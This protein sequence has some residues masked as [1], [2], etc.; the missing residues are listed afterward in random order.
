MASVDFDAWMDQC[1]GPGTV[2]YA[3]R[4]SA[5]DTLAN[6][7]HQAG[8]YIPREVLFTVLPILDRPERH[9]PDARFPLRID[10]HDGAPR[11]VR[12]IWYNNAL[13]G[14]TRNEARVTGFGGRRSPLL[15]PEN[16]GAV[17]VFAFMAGH[18][19]TVSQCRVWVCDCEAEESLF[20]QRLGPL[21]PGRWLVWSPDA[22][23]LLTPRPASATPCRL[24][25][26]DIPTAWLSAFP[27]GAEIVAET[28][29]MRPEHGYGPDDRL[30][31]RRD[32]EYEIFLSVE[33]AVEMPGIRAGF[34]TIDEFVSRA[35]SILQRRKARAGRSLELHAR[36]IFV[37][38]GLIEDEHFA[39]G[40]DSEPGRR[41]D[42]LFPSQERYRDHSFP[43]DRLRM[44]AVKTTCRDR[45]RQI[46]NEAGRIPIKHLL[47]VQEGVSEAQFREM[48]ESGVRLVV[49][50]RLR[51]HYPAVLRPELTSLEEFIADIRPLAGPTP[52][53]EGHA[54]PPPS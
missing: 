13:H 45:W 20:E 14:G 17:T 18:R 50:S 47:T 31:R 7:T 36:Q 38:E 37:E 32:C 26:E 46:L 35:Q 11:M 6:R 5:N 33:E 1:S 4:L 24:A 22:T 39:H 48:K 30:L 9:N 40:A 3:K 54:T 10:S 19:G 41:P 44:L 16:T 27:S 53:R 12:T 34:G 29:K 49:P 52:G 23:P 42:F 28:V 21:E 2:W 8:P 43:P 51:A 15:D 25:L